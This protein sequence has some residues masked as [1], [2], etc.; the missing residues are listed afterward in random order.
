[1]A[2][3]TVPPWGRGGMD[4]QKRATVKRFLIGVSGVWLVL[5]SWV[6]FFA[7]PADEVQTINSPEVKDRMR[8][9]CT[10]TFQQRY[11]C[12]DSIILE[13][14]QDAFANMTLRLVL[15][16]SVPLLAAI[17]YHTVCRR[18][19]VHRL[20]DIED[21]AWKPSPLP[22][23]LRPRPPDQIAADQPPP[24]QSD[25]DWKRRAQD[26]IINARPPGPMDEAPD[27]K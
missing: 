27:D 4:R 9:E 26:R 6:A 25:D 22:P 23:L 13:V 16:V 5:G 2:G 24:P 19:P 11:R 15:V 18:D 20:S 21:V 10:G 3:G 12:K 17:A 8:D 7:L 1:M 14:G